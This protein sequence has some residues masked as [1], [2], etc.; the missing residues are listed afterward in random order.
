MRT[1]S[2]LVREDAARMAARPQ[3]RTVNNLSKIRRAGLN[4]FGQPYTGNAIRGVGSR[5]TGGSTSAELAAMERARQAGIARAQAAAGASAPASAPAKKPGRL[6]PGSSPGS[7]IWK[8]DEE[9]PA[10]A[11]ASSGGNGLF[12]RLVKTGKNAMLAAAR[13]QKAERAM[14]D[15]NF[16]RMRVALEKVHGESTTKGHWAQIRDEWRADGSLNNRNPDA[17]EILAK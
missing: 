7:S 5:D 17:E 12:G 11:P 15:R 4:A 16:S 13:R 10:P 2:R 8:T 9:P 1:T 14:Q 3:G 6:I